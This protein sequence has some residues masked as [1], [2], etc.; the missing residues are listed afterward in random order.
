MTPG[1]R[2]F[3]FSS[4]VKS[5]EYSL[6]SGKQVPMYGYLLKVANIMKARTCKEWYGMQMQAD[7]GLWRVVGYNIGKHK[8]ANYFN[9]VGEKILVDVKRS[10]ADNSLCFGDWGLIRKAS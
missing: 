6:H 3:D 5:S 7:G 1:K 9:N 10:L 8:E 2:V 4:P